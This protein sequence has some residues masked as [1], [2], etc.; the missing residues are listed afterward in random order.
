MQREAGIQVNHTKEP[1]KSNGIKGK[2]EIVM[3]F[4]MGR[5]KG[6]GESLSGV[7]NNI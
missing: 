6:K 3:I 4:Y 5:K 2:R 7:K 1:G